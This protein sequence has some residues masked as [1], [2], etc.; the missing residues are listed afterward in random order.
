[1]DKKLRESIE[2]W[3]KIS[4]FWSNFF[5]DI[6]RIGVHIDMFWDGKVVEIY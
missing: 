5:F 1:M 2:K 3:S 4:K 6:D